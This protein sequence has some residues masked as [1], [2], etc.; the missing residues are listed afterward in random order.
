MTS[1]VMCLK[2]PIKNKIMQIGFELL[3]LKY[4]ELTLMTTTVSIA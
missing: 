4:K 3:N 1:R 2:V